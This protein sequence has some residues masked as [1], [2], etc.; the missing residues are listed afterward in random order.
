MLVNSKRKIQEDKRR[1]TK[2]P[3][4]INTQ[5]YGTNWTIRGRWIPKHRLYTER[6]TSTTVEKTSVGIEIFSF[7]STK[8]I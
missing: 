6:K 7:D 8:N 5:S 2:I 4:K 1:T 3:S